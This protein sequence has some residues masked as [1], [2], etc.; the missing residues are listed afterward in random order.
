M[1][2]KIIF[3]VAMLLSVVAATAQIKFNDVP[4]DELQKMAMNEKKLIFIDVYASWCP[5]CKVLVRDVFSRKDVGDFMS[6]SFVS[7][8]YDIDQHT[9]R[10]IA[11]KYGIK[12]IP[13]LL[14][15]KA[16]GTLVHMVQ[17]A[18]PAKEFMEEMSAALAK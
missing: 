10:D 2:R 14:V 4:L 12:S 1:V 17:G 3:S 15:F 9:G 18:M 13:T 16:D 6:K 11:N 5:P 8:K 7:A